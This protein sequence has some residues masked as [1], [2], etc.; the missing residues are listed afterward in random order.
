MYRLITAPRLFT[1]LDDRIIRDGAVLIE[2][3][4]IVAAGS[5]S[6]IGVPVGPVERIDLPTGTIVPGLID[7]HTHLTCSA[8]DQMVA[9]GFSDHDI[10][11]TIRAANHA[12]GAVRAGVTTVRD[13]GSRHSVVS[14]LRDAIRAGLTPGPRMLLSGSVITTVGGHMYFVGREVRGQD[15]M[16]QAVREQVRD[17]ADF[18][19]VTAT[20]GGLVPGNPI[21]YVEFDAED[22]GLIVEEA[23]RL[24]VHV[25]AHTL[26]TE[27]VAHVV[28]ARPRT[29]E[30]LTFY[31]DPSET[32][33]YDP[34]LV[35]GLIER[36]IWASQVIIGWHRRA[37]GPL[38]VLRADLDDEMRRKVEER[39]G[40]LNRMYRQGV[41]FVTGSDAGMPRTQFDNFGLILDLTVRHIGL[42]VTETLHAATSV[43]AEAL[44]LSDRGTLAPGTLA[45]LA[46]F[47]G[48]PHADLH[49]FYRCGLAM[50]G[51]EVVWRA[52]AP[53]PA[54]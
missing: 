7:T 46:V 35:D 33:D 39:A 6:E 30:H 25:A 16:L 20:G 43:A 1:G 4:R 22:L 21:H 3:E 29:A 52:G 27:S 48:D 23:A 49:A 14:R 32:V 44:G 42:S 41:R 47:T 36:G 19:K 34:K 45:D 51:G 11:A 28:A 2:G 38:G 54:V 12:R 31:T 18:I 15:D 53:A 9:E 50:I 5:A 10:T 40:I 37:H 26:S 24:G 17:G 8:T 13:C